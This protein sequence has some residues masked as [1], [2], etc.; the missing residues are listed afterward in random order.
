LIRG[1]KDLSTSNLV[2]VGERTNSGRKAVVGEGSHIP[3][4]PLLQAIVAAYLTR[5]IANGSKMSDEVRRD[6]LI[7]EG[8]ISI[9]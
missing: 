2:F 7:S 4:D 3:A 5:T 8:Q 1:A 6:D 9:P